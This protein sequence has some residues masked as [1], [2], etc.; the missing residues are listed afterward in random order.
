MT[1]GGS[2]LDWHHLANQLR[3]DG[4]GRCS[5]VGNHEIRFNTTGRQFDTAVMMDCSQCPVQPQLQAAFHDAVRRN[6]KLL[7]LAGHANDA[8]VI[9]AG[10]YLAAC[11][12]YAAL[13]RKSPVGLDY[14]TGLDAELATLLQAAAWETSQ[15][16]FKP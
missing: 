5:F 2:G 4:L 15:D 11:T 1:V 10:T 14:T 9:P 6:A 7:V 12:A 3:P 16:Y 8:L 13:Y